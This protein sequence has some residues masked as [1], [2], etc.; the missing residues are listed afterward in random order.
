[1]VLTNIGSIGLDEGFAPLPCPMHV[2][3]VACAGKINKKPVVRD[4]EIVIRDIMT[5]VYTLDHR[6]GD[7][8]VLVPFCN[9]VKA[10]LEDPENFDPNKFPQLPLYEDRNTDKKLA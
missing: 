4:G 1:M 2:C 3:I 10:I 9:V 8:S 6:F 5:I 7:A